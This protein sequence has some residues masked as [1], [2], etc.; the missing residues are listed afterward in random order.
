MVATGEG[1]G[2]YIPGRG[3]I[4]WLNFT[5]QAGHEQ[6]CHRPALILSPRAYNELT[7]MAVCC[8][9]TSRVRDYP[10]HIPLPDAGTI[11]GVVMVDQIRSLDWQGRRAR[12]ECHCPP[13]VVEEVLYKVNLILN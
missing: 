6:A 3:E 9:I 7:G 4:V 8:P 13:E 12:F 1:S 10:F 11:A 5:A 2:D